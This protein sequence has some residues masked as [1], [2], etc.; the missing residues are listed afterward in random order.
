MADLLNPTLANITNVIV[1]YTCVICGQELTNVPVLDESKSVF[2]PYAGQYLQMM[3]S[4]QIRH[5]CQV[6]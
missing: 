3:I 6:A 4:S 2:D 1:S 5:Q